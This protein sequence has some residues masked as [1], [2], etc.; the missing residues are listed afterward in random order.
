MH[1]PLGKELLKKYFDGT[2]TDSE[3]MIVDQWYA[4]RLFTNL[5][6]P[7]EADYEKI[8]SEVWASI[9]IDDRNKIRHFDVWF[10]YI[11]VAAAVALV[12]FGVYFFS[13]NPTDALKD[14]AESGVD[15]APG[16][17][18]AT[19]TL[20]NGKKIRLS[21]VSAGELAKE[22]G[23]SITKT[24][25]GK[26]VYSIEETIANP[27]TVN[28][29]STDKG[30]TYQ[31][32]LPDGSIV[33]LNAASSLTYKTSLM[34]EGKR[35]VKLSGEG[36]FE[37]AKQTTAKGRVPFI[38]ESRGQKVEVLGTH[39][40]INAYPESNQIKT[41]LL[42]GSIK[43]IKGKSSRILV[44]GEEANIDTVTDK[45]TV[46]R[47]PEPEMSIAW[48]NGR[49]SF[50]MTTIKEAMQQISRWYDVEVNYKGD[51]SDVLL[52][53][54]IARTENASEIL[55]LLKGTH[56]VDFIISGR[57]ITVIPYPNKSN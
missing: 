27:N 14:V 9:K 24:A 6:E 29:F 46:E 20:A 38:V 35:V 10:K 17:Y 26:L 37:I 45:I 4:Q 54:D 48:K 44:S 1:T 51:F 25:D 52:T 40:N 47:S 43:L 13:Y 31:V 11:S 55:K 22:S 33:H 42:E 30:E 41:T 19:L 39:F 2:A 28:T 5:T 34:E 8:K 32:H 21:D 12:V 53:G 49:F 7:K 18:G 50:D 56:Q 15:I 36:Y 23:V 3:R 16:S 57:T